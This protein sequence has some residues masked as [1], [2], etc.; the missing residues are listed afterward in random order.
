MQGTSLILI[1][2]IL[3]P[4]YAAEEVGLKLRSAGQYASAA[5]YMQHITKPI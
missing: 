5:V 3:L 4:M 2:L 1:D